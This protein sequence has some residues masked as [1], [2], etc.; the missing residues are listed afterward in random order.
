MYWK[1]VSSQLRG[2]LHCATGSLV[3]AMLAS[4]PLNT[5]ALYLAAFRL[6]SLMSV[7]LLSVLLLA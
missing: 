2:C 6:Q 7:I 4:V 1:R 3:E 5:A